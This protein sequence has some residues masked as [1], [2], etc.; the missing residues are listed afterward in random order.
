[1]NCLELRR[2]AMLDPR[3]LGDVA[4]EHAEQCEACREFLSRTF[5]FE[6]ELAQ[7]LR[8]PVPDGAK[9]RAVR[10]AVSPAAARQPRWMALAAGF[11]LAVALGVGL[12]WPR[13]DPM[14]L[15]GIDFV[16]FEEA[17]AILDAKPVE[18]DALHRVVGQLGIAL[19]EQLGEMR[20]VGTCPFVGAIA[21]H[22][23]V[24]TAMGKVTLLL[25]PERA[26]T[27]RV[28]AAA[29]GL[30]AVITPVAGGSVA[31]VAGSPHSVERTEMLLKAI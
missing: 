23:V 15:A 29:R 22:V 25:M 20:Y 16:V 17:Q 7:T 12:V 19:P 13:N 6:I 1:M 31:I 8:V 5:Q 3:H 18:P 27:V 21:H 11:L 9:E 4:M 24:K 26:I 10:G 30:E 14:A 2:M 28:A